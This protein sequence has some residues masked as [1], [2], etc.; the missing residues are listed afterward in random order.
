MYVPLTAWLQQ[1]ICCIH[2]LGFHDFQCLLPVISTV[3]PRSCWSGHQNSW[4]Y[5]KGYFLEHAWWP[6]S[7]FIGWDFIIFFLV[8]ENFSPPQTTVYL[9]Q[10]D[11]TGTSEGRVHPC[12]TPTISPPLILTHLP[13]VA[14]CSKPMAA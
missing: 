10:T 12:F 6:F 4:L 3:S 7:C 9:K 8:E 13:F 5:N 1:V 2:Q 11:L 14:F